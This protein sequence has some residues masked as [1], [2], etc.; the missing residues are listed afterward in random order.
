MA[1]EDN[2][3]ELLGLSCTIA[4]ITGVVPST[5]LDPAIRAVQNCFEVP[6]VIKKEG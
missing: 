1:F 5:Q 6:N 2:G 4:S 3:I